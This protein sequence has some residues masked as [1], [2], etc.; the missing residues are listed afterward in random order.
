MITTGLSARLK[1]AGQDGTIARSL[2]EWNVFSGMFP[3]RAEAVVK[4][5]RPLFSASLSDK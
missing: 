5:M 2:V 1:A 3:M 4:K